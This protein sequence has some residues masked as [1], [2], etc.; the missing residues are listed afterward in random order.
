MVAF[1]RIG[2]PSAAQ[3]VRLF[4]CR[5]SKHMRARQHKLIS[6][7]DSVAAFRP[8]QCWSDE[9]KKNFT[10]ICS[11]LRRRR[12]VAQMRRR[13]EM[14]PRL[15]L[16]EA[17]TTARTWALS[18]MRSFAYLCTVMLKYAR[19]GSAVALSLRVHANCYCTLR[20]A[21]WAQLELPANLYASVCVCV[22]AIPGL[23]RTARAVILQQQFLIRV[24][25]FHLRTH[26]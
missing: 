20:C 25:T 11:H 22:C 24:S 15:L 21:I 17:L 7:L 6:A 16:S 1:P 10:A 8:L 5:H 12:S 13:R 2:L 14:S 4:F 19:R 3:C 18:P 26:K 9:R 23:C